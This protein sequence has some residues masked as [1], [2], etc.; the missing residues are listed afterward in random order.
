MAKQTGTAGLR[1]YV[2]VEAGMFTVAVIEG[3]GKV[4]WD[5]QDCFGKVANVTTTASARALTPAMMPL[6]AS[7]PC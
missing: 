7:I 6:R 1:V 5:I 2:D 4:S 3:T